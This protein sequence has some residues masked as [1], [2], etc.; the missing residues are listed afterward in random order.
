MI[1]SRKPKMPNE[2]SGV[3]RFSPSLSGM[4]L[5]VCG[6]SHRSMTD[7]TM[8]PATVP[9]IDP[10]PPRMIIERIRIENENWNW[11]ASIAGT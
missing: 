2:I 9:Q 1:T 11:F 5:N 3:V 7:S 6:K 4:S 8:A 10:R